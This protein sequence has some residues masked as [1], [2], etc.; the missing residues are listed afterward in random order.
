MSATERDEAA[1]AAWREQTAAVDARRFVWVD[2]TGSHL[3][4]TPTHARA[5]RGQRARGSV[6]RNRGRATTLLASLTTAGMG[7]ATTVEGGTTAE[8]FAAYVD[9]V[10]APALR[11][12]QVVV[13]D[14][15]AAHQAARV[16][17][18]VEA[19]DGIWLSHESWGRRKLAYEIGRKSEGTYHF[20]TFDALPETVEEISR[21]LKIA[22][23]VLRFLAVRRV[24]SKPDGADREPE[25]AATNTRSSEEEE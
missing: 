2:E 14:N 5:P 23:E 21:V 24:E 16:R 7:P 8:V 20:V 17:E 15:L 11:P 6:P 18:L 4:L 1:R 12:G 10:P 25:Y 3:A 19:G 9:Q 22:D 13:W